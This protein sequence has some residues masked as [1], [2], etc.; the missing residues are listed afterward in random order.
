MTN[1]DFMSPIHRSASVRP[2][3][4]RNFFVPL[5]ELLAKKK[6]AYLS[7]RDESIRSGVGV[8]LQVNHTWCLNFFFNLA[9]TVSP[10]VNEVDARKCK[11]YTEIANTHNI[12]DEQMNN[13]PA[14]LRMHVKNECLLLEIL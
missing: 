5:A 9:A 4:F 11:S 7:I 3:Y 10:K 14:L 6:I 13:A 12:A 8:A 2:V 1:F